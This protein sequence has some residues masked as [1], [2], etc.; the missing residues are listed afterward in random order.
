MAVLTNFLPAT[1]GEWIDLTLIAPVAPLGS[2]KAPSFMGRVRIGHAGRAPRG[3]NPSNR[4]RLS[5]TMTHVDAAPRHRGQDQ[6]DA[7]AGRRPCLRRT[8][9]LVRYVFDHVEGATLDSTGE[10]SAKS[11]K[12]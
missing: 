1:S 5:A 6:V 12:R 11:E 8:G 7:I 3:G 10:P 2:I 9:S 4:T